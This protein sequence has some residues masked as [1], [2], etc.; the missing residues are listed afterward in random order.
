M[1]FYLSFS[2]TESRW[3]ILKSHCCTVQAVRHLSQNMVPI[4]H[5]LVDIIIRIFIGIQIN[6]IDTDTIGLEGTICYESK[7]WPSL[8]NINKRN[9]CDDTQNKVT[10]TNVLPSLI[11]IKK[12]I[13]IQG[14]RCLQMFLCMMF[15]RTLGI[16]HTD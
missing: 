4:R 6:T 16:E 1:Y 10:F 9:T 5:I 2:A 8:H 12:I 3:F 11:V 15:A 7:H 13:N 14:M